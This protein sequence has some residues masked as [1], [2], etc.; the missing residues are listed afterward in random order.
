MY[1]ENYNIGG[2]KYI[3]INKAKAR[4]AFEQGKK[5]LL[6]PVGMR[7]DSSWCYSTSISKGDGR[8][9]EDLVFSFTL[10]NCSPELGK[11]PKFFVESKE[12]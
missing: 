5:I 9:F 4:K 1:Q 3:R 6:T 12:V 10:Y 8:E 2:K 11:Y 7:L